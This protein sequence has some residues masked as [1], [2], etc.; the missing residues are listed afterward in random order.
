MGTSHQHIDIY[1]ERTSPEFWAEPINALTN[2][3]FLIA[4]F[5]AFRLLRHEGAVGMRLYLLPALIFSIGIGSFLFHTFAT[6]WAAASDVLPILLFQIAFLIYFAHDVL[7]LKRGKI[8]ALLVLYILLTLMFGSLPQNWLNGSLSY[9]PALIF[10]WGF[11]WVQWY[12]KS[13]GAKAF[14]TAGCLFVLSLTFRS[15]DMALCDLIPIGVHY[16]WHLFNAAVLFLAIQGYA[17]AVHKDSA[18]M[19]DKLR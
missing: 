13:E 14:I 12:K 17:R 19:T 5:F 4:A 10:L 9:A 15:V 3:A 2:A 16:F 7:Q 11:A 8:A 18:D 1:C 6:P